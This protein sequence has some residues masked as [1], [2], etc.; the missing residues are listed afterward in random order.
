MSP[1][2]SLRSLDAYYGNFGA[3]SVLLLD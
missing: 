1:D 2:L 3:L